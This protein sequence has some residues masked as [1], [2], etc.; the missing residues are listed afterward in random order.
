MVLGRPKAVLVLSPQQR[1]QLESLASSRALPAGL[2]RRARIIS[3][4]NSRIARPTW[5]CRCRSTTSPAVTGAQ[6]AALPEVVEQ[7]ESTTIRS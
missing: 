2:V 5:L 3:I 4:P 7:R 6:M 1:E